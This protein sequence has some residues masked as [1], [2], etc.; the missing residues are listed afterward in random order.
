M[1]NFWG[2]D[3]CDI[4]YLVKV[5][6]FFHAKHGL[7]LA[8]HCDWP[9]KAF[10]MR[11]KMYVSLCC[12]TW[13]PMLVSSCLRTNVCVTNVRIQAASSVQQAPSNWHHQTEKSTLRYLD[14]NYCTTVI[15]VWQWWFVHFHLLNLPDLCYRRQRATDYWYTNIIGLHSGK[16]DLIG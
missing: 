1:K 16:S 11:F 7:Q 14:W 15:G 3:R 6:R 5:K 12:K 8:Q 13:C 4:H 2:C 9:S 10:K